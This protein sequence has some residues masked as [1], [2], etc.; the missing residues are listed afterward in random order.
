M[1]FIV[2]LLKSFYIKY[3]VRLQM[4]FTTCTHALYS[5][6]LFW[7]KLT[8]NLSLH[9]ML[10][11]L[12][13]STQCLANTSLISDHCRLKQQL[14]LQLISLNAVLLNAVRVVE[15]DNGAKVHFSLIN[16]P[17]LFPEATHTHTQ[18]ITHVHTHKHTRVWIL[19]EKGGSK[20]E[21]NISRLSILSS[22]GA[23]QSSLEITNA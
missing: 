11:W 13:A 2:L 3:Y 18:I 7:L 19:E 5:M 15:Q 4:Y 22:T 14:L 1:Y 17:L 6:F 21:G 8:V 23:S 16:Y 9:I 12:N 10:I 20:E